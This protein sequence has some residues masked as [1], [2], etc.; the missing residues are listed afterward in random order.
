MV[1][2]VGIEDKHYLCNNVLIPFLR[3]EN[4]FKLIK[5]LRFRFKYIVGNYVQPQRSTHKYMGLVRRSRKSTTKSINTI[6]AKL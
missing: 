6:K 3:S 5:I 4:N 1:S 2:K